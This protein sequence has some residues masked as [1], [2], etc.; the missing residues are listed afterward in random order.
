MTAASLALFAPGANAQVPPGTCMIA[1]PT[2][3]PLNLRDG[4]NGPILGKLYNGD[5]VVMHRT[6]RDARGRSWAYI[7]A[8]NMD[9]WV[10]REYIACRR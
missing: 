1:D 7:S 8:R 6:T 5:F 9:G 3:T 2:G 10:F 4:P